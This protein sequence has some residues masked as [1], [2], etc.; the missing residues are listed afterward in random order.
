MERG[1]GQC[2]RCG[3][4]TYTSR[5]GLCREHWEKRAWSKDKEHIRVYPNGEIDGDNVLI[6]GLASIRG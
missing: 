2:V 1:R 4:T 3:R 5:T 6:S